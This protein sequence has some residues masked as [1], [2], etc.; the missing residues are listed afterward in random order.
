LYESKSLVKALAD[1]YGRGS[2]A[3][4]PILQGII[5]EHSYLSDTAMLD[6]AKELDLSAAHV[7]GTASFYSFLDHKERGKYVIR[8]C[9]TISCDMKG[10]EQILHAIEETL[11]IK[12]GETTSD[13]KFTLLETNCMGW[14]HKA[15]AMLIN[16]IPYTE[17]TPDKV[18]EIIQDYQQ[19]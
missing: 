7:F 13:K 8:I 5:A 18:I 4:M 11:K 12:H 16:D 10:K 17:L 6:V 14:C 2:E 1:K 15:P 19:K 3:L 9:R